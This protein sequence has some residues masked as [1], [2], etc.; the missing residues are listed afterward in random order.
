MGSTLNKGDIV[1]IVEN[2][3]DMGTES[4]EP[5][6]RDAEARI[7]EVRYLN[8][9]LIDYNVRLLDEDLHCALGG[10]EEAFVWPFYENELELV[11]RA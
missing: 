3:Y 10:D 5:K 11:R 9:Q 2:G 1:R 8:G 6:F 7:E 4:T